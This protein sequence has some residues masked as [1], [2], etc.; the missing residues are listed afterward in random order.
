[1]TMHKINTFVLPMKLSSIAAAALIAAFCIQALLAL[2][3]LSATADEPIHL[4]AGYSYWQTR[5]FRM[6][7]EHPPLVKL[8]AGL[9]LLL[10]RPKF[11]TS[12][13]DWPNAAQDIFG[14]RFLY[15][16]DADRLLF[17]GRMPMVL[18]AALGG[19]VT[20]FW[21]RD[22]F[23]SAAGVFA[24]G[25]YSFSPNLLAHGMLVTTDVPLAVFWLLTLYLFWKQHD[26]PSW[27]SDAA[28]GLALG[29]AMASKFSGAFLPVILIVLCFARNGRHA[30]KH[31]F[32]IA[33]AALVV[34]EAAYLF[35]ASP[36]LYFKNAALVNANHIANYPFI[37]SAG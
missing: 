31:L 6:N 2:P 26:N 18:V 23:G 16:N 21:A 28:V 12:H 33:C 11:D 8:L 19:V 24:T 5:D 30:L 13:A 37:S 10:L 17:W 25:L 3:Q 4:A 20:F 9:P 32:I 22:L 34:I 27:R 7:P 1:M 15:G 35:S 36:I 14:F 29:A